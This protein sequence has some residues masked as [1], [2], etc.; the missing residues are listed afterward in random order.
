MN[1]SIFSLPSSTDVKSRIT[2][3]KSDFCH[4][5]RPLILLLT[6]VEDGETFHFCSN[7]GLENPSF[8][9]H[10]TET[11]IFGLRPEKTFF[12][13]ELKFTQRD[14]LKGEP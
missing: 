10:K 9:G 2:D 11:V 13:G 4:F 6:V 12:Q 7:R 1:I 3:V 14:C 5:S 8:S